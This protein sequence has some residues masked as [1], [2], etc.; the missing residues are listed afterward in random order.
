LL[1]DKIISADEDGD[2]K[3]SWDEFI[4]QLNK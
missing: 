2:G 1:W 4:H 3:L